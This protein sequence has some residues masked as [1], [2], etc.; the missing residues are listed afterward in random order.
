MLGFVNGL[1]IVIFRSQFEMFELSHHIPA[2]EKTLIWTVM[3][4]LI[5]VTMAISFFMP[6]ITKAVPA[7]LTALV[8][9]SL[10]SLLLNHL[11]IVEVSTVLDFVQSKDPAKLTL[12]ATLPHFEIPRS[13][14]PWKL[15][16]PSSHIRSWQLLSG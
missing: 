15:S 9:V 12:A 10:I 2:Q 7:T 3:G 16:G 1:A 14:L 4:I 8:V 13:P 6:K 11:E 5:L